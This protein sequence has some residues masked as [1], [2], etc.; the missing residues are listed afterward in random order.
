MQELR[1]GLQELTEANLVDLKNQYQAATNHLQALKATR[2][3]INNAQVDMISHVAK[4]ITGISSSTLSGESPIASQV[5]EAIPL[6]DT[7]ESAVKSG[8]EGIQSH[9]VKV[10]N[11]LDDLIVK[12]QESYREFSTKYSEE[13]SQLSPEQKRLLESHRK[14]MDDTKDLMTLEVRKAELKSEVESVLKELVLLCERVAKT[15]DNKSSLRESRVAKFNAL[16]RPYDVRLTVVRQRNSSDFEELSRKYA[17]GAKILNELKSKLP[18]RLAHLCLKKAYSNMIDDLWSGYSVSVFEYGDFTH[19]LN[20]FEEDDLQIELK[21][22]KAGQEY[23]PINELSAGQRCTSVFPVLLK[24][25]EGPLI[26]DQ[27]ED[28]LDNRHIANVIA[29]ALIDDKK[30]RQLLFTSHN[31]NLVVM[32]DPE[33][34]VHFDSNGTKGWIE[35]QGFLATKDSRITKHVLDILDGG[36]NALKLRIQKYAGLSVAA[37]IH[38]L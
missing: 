10:V 28:N 22:G 36:E 25:G 33:S 1:K 11:L 31:A 15:L 29:P 3:S 2:D 19:F 37:Y 14:L 5:A 17:N 23:S 24:L 18:D 12:V 9:M 21:V 7:M 26:I 34:I 32:S 30:H 20:I 6:I 8:A 27:P 38:Q 13:V 35:C 16:L 4:H